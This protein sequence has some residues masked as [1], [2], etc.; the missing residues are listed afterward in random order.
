MMIEVGYTYV[1]AVV[2]HKVMN[3]TN[4][5]GFRMIFYC[6]YLIDREYLQRHRV[7]WLLFT[8]GLW[9]VL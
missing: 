8:A 1:H 5:L 4:T 9:C 2:M 6:T 7:L 3:D